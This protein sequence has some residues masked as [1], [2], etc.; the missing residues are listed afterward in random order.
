MAGTESI[1]KSPRTVARDAG[2]K[3]Y[4]TGKPCK[5]GHVSERITSNGTCRACSRKSGAKFRLENPEKFAASTAATKAKRLIRRDELLELRRQVKLERNPRLAI[6][7]ANKRAR[8]EGLAAGAETYA[9]LGACKYGHA[10]LRFTK[11]YGCVECHS[12]SLRP[13]SPEV[14]A[15]RVERRDLLKQR[16]L[17][18]AQVTVR[19]NAAIAIG[20]K[21]FVGSPCRLGHSGLRWVINHSCVECIRMPEKLDGKCAYDRAYRLAHPEL[22]ERSKQWSKKN[23]AR[24]K[25]IVKAYTARRRSQEK[26]GDP[27]RVVHEWETSAKKVCYWCGVKCQKNYHIDHYQPLSKGGAH[28]VAN[29]VIACPRCNLTK[30]AKD[31]YEFAASVGRL[32]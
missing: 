3:L 17:A 7:R 22:L 24:R 18:K 28:T 20:E 27:T 25:S 8:A 21:T 13:D 11:S 10:G 2:E 23:P 1:T 16:G 6:S 9:S 5:Q 19:R 4:F 30:N 15:A 12:L 14:V 26:T 32:F 29:L 31:P